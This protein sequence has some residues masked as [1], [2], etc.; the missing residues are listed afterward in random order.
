MYDCLKTF[1]IFSFASLDSWDLL[2]L[3][4]YLWLFLFI[5]YFMFLIWVKE[6]NFYLCCYLWQNWKEVMMIA[7]I[8][9]NMEWH[10]LNLFFI[11]CF[12][13][14]SI[15][16]CLVENTTKPVYQSS[17]SFQ[18]WSNYNGCMIRLMLAQVWD[19]SYF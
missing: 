6:N 18:K 19:N 10:I 14:R 15:I 13:L 3:I 9:K 2:L 16:F 4:F 5:C 1:S 7:N 11:V 8:D 12:N 17:F